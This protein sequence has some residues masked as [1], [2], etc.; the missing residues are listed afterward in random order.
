MSD[1]ERKM[2][3][4]PKPEPVGET[5]PVGQ[6]EGGR[7]VLLDL[8]GFEVYL[9]PGGGLRFGEGVVGPEPD[10]RTKDDARDVCLYPHGDG[11][12]VLYRMYRGTGEASVQRTMEREGIRYDI[13]VLSPGKVGS[14]YVKTVGHIH[15][16]APGGM[17]TY[18]EVYQV[19]YGKAHF[20]LQRGGELSG[21]VEDFAVAD[22]EAGDILIVWP[23][24]GHVTVNPG[25][26]YLVMAN[27]VARNFKSIYDPI[28]QRKG[29]T[30][31]NVEHKDQSIFIPN[32]NYSRHPR[33]RLIKPRDWHEFGLERG[34]SMY[35]LWKSGRARMDFLTD[36]ARYREVWAREGIRP[37]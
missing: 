35:S 3:E 14:E 5:R 31:Y 21:E 36:P 33:P 13:T 17:W 34:T 19:L 23:N 7:E 15:P 29:L 12:P 2:A 24:Y 8:A 6:E 27:F 28:R 25:D 32:D 10:L 9:K 16:V 18:P 11:P 20:L 1:E 37:L 22:F 4:N 30:Y 26:S